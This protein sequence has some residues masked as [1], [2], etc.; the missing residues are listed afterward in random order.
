MLWAWNR[1]N[2]RSIPEDRALQAFVRVV[3]HPVMRSDSHLAVVGLSGFPGKP[4]FV[5]PAKAGIQRFS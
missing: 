2:P 1:P 3:A 5:I 4:H